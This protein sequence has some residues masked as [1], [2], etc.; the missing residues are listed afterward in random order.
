MPTLEFHLTRQLLDGT[1]IVERAECNEDEVGTA[2][3]GQWVRKDIGWKE[4]VPGDEIIIRCRLKGER[5][6][7]PAVNQAGPVG[8][9]PL[10]LTDASNVSARLSQLI[11]E[12][13]QVADLHAQLSVQA[14]E[15]KDQISARADDVAKL[16]RK[17]NLILGV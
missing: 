9:N 5:S 2:F 11:A 16:Q 1:L 10:K 6:A 17:I 13:N 15:L 3:N 8:A 14:E 4:I 12:R 7:A